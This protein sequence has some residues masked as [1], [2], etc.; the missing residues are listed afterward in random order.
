MIWNKGHIVKQMRMA[1]ELWSSSKKIEQ[2]TLSAKRTGLREMSMEDY[3]QSYDT[4]VRAYIKLKRM[5]K[6][7][8]ESNMGFILAKSVNRY[9]KATE[10]YLEAMLCQLCPK[11]PDLLHITA[12]MQEKE[13]E[14]FNAAGWND[15]E[16]EELLNNPYLE[17]ELEER[18]KIVRKIQQRQNDVPHI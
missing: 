2:N 11:N 5:K 17:Y 6:D 14:K 13:R 18:N 4:A 16:D 9:I 1:W 3:K 12:D 10:A 8:R 15:D 7:A